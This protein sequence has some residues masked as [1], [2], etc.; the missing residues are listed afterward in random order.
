M[1]KKDTRQ[2]QAMLPG[3]DP[4]VVESAPSGDMD[5]ALKLTEEQLAITTRVQLGTEHLLVEALAGSGK[6]STIIESLKATTAKKVLLCAFNKAN[7][8]A[9]EAKMPKPPRG[10]VQRARTAHAL[11]YSILKA[12]GCP[13]DMDLPATEMLVHDVANAIEAV[14]TADR[15]Q[16][17]NDD[18]PIE[19]WVPWFPV[20]FVEGTGTAVIPPK[21]RR[22]ATTLLRRLKETCIERDVGEDAIEILGHEIDAFARI[23][24]IDVPLVCTIVRLAYLSGMRLD[25]AA[26]DYCDQVWLPMVLD[27]EPRMRFDLIFVDEAQDFSKPQFALV[28]R[29]KTDDGRLVVVG[30]LCQSVYGWRGAVGDEVWATMLAAEAVRMPL[31]VSFRCARAIVEEAN[32]IVEALKPCPGAPEG[33]VRSCSFMQFLKE[34]SSTRVSCFVIS[35]NNA[36]L[37]QTAVQLWRQK[38]RFR[39]QKSEETAS[40]LRAIIEKLDLSNAERFSATLDEWYSTERE[41]AEERSEVW[42][43]RL[44]QQYEMLGAMLQHAEPR[45]LVRVLDDI[46]SPKDSQVTLSTVH[47]VKG[48]EA[49]RV[50]LLQQTFARHQERS[51]LDGD[52]S[53]PQEELNLEYVAITRA[54]RELVWVD[55]SDLKTLK[56]QRRLSNASKKL[57]GASPG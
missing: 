1:R 51:I 20:A 34:L 11:G 28:Q 26:I 30:D 43:D 56:A 49:D 46:F 24:W 15:I 48:F 36:S 5:R 53:I 19:K 6:T 57:S 42:A 52:P 21:V 33:Q 31:T 47:G 55:L 4:P 7:R 27:L 22:S 41:L 10:R 25:R 23:D 17:G 44:D 38:E 54:R 16:A 35:R 12:H 29:M 13:G 45:N 8:A 2:D 3:F 37:F 40:G 9:L 14:I 50:Y 32:G 39:Y 18:V